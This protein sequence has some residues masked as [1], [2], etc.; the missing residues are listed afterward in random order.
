MSD[1]LKNRPDSQVFN[2]WKAKLLKH[3]E[4]AQ[5]TATTLYKNNKRLQAKLLKDGGKPVNYVKTN[6]AIPITT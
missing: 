1:K 2:I 3:E 5:A 4:K 6:K